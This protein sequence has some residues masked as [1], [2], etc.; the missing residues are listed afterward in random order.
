M[1][2]KFTEQDFDTFQEVI[3]F[4]VTKPTWSLSTPEAIQLNK[5]LAFLN[6]VNSKIK[7]N[8]LEVGPEKKVSKP[9]RKKS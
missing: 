3:K 8:I 2:N 4:L 7:S 6:Q 1:E 9:T 5:Y